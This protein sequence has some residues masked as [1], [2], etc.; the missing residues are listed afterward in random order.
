VEQELADAV[1][2][3]R[4]KT[5]MAVVMSPKTGDVLAMASV[6]YFNPNYAS[7]AE[8]DARRNRTVTD[9]TEPGSVIKPLI[10]SA[11]LAGGFVTK[12]ER[13]DCHLGSHRFGN[14]VIKDVSPQ[15][16]ADIKSI[17]IKSSNIGMAQIG[18]R[19]GAQVLYETVRG[20]GLGA[21]TG[22]ECP[23]ESA[24]VVHP[25][26]AWGRMTTQSVSFGY[27]IGVTPLQLIT[28]YTTLINE[29]VRIKPRLVRGLLDT[30]GEI[31]AWSEGPETLGRAAPA[32]IANYIRD[33]L[34]VAVINEG[35]AASSMP[36]RYR[37]LGKT[38]TTKL[39][40]PGRKGYVSGQYQSTF[41]GAAPAAD[42]EII[43]LVMIR[44]P[45]PAIG[46]YGATVAA[47]SAGRMIEQVLAYLEV[48]PDRHVE[49]A[50][51]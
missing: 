6:P 51:M 38:G 43:V 20:F 49:F 37:V 9:P 3:F 40:E 46:Y 45:D 2:S 30:D 4:A 1:Q 11:A 25:L 22:I 29:G 10:I 15:G 24:G 8:P 28:A 32:A 19:M 39:T 13:I 27:E 23:G 5:G 16:M 34:L 7:Q 17:I 36:E 33:E 48:P 41:I 50:G 42:P 21:C 26:S 44:R 12:H 31:A 18:E 35:S 47:P 14:R